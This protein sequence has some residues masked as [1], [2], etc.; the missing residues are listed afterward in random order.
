[1]RSRQNGR[2]FPDDIFKWI[3]LWENV[4][5]SIKIS[6][7]FVLTIPINN[8][9]ALVQIMAWRRSG[10]KPLSELIMD[11]LLTHICVTRPQWGNVCKH[12][13]YFSC[14]HIQSW[15]LFFIV[16]DQS[17]LSVNIKSKYP[18]CPWRSCYHRM[19]SNAKAETT[20]KLKS[21]VSVNNRSSRQDNQGTTTIYSTYNFL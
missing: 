5:I 10:D 12:P 3:F 6:L 1:M 16:I 21:T 9:P 17:H 13:N 20:R 7:K 15:I 8:I 18:R 14:Y 4:W 11:S 2:H 19:P